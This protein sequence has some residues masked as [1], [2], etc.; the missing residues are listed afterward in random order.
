M[1]CFQQSNQENSFSAKL[2]MVLDHNIERVENQYCLYLFLVRMLGFQVVV[3][4]LLQISYIPPLCIWQ[5]VMCMMLNCC[6]E[7]I[8]KCL[9]FYSLL[10]IIKLKA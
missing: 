6:K 2:S 3:Q 10:S 7:E 8:E 1:F 5:G 4:E 9:Y